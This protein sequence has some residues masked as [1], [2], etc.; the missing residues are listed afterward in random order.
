MLNMCKAF[1]PAMAAL[2][3]EGGLEWAGRRVSHTNSNNSKVEGHLSL[4]RRGD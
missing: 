3:R 1:Y 4:T 2:A